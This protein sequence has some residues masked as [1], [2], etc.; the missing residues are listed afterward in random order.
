V[1]EVKPEAAN[2]IPVNSEAALI[3]DILKSQYF[4]DVRSVSQA[5]VRIRLGRALGLD[6]A[7]AMMG[8]FINMQGK[9]SMSANL[10][11][12][13]IKTKLNAKGLR[14][15][16]YKILEHTAQKCAIQVWERIDDDW[17]EC[18]PPEVS[19]IEQFKFLAVGPNKSN[20]INY[21]KNMLFARCISNIAK[22]H[23]A[24]VF[25]GSPVYLPDEIPNSGLEVDGETLEVKSSPTVPVETEATPW[26][27]AHYELQQLMIECQTDGAWLKTALGA[28]S[29]GELS[30]EAARRGVEFLRKRQELRSKVP[31]A[32]AP[33]GTV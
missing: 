8:L 20:W 10:M 31:A 15:Y 1:S 23:C 6:E 27:P 17:E 32:T 24:D 7:S 25:G 33:A 16:K 9:L 19:T 14:Q 22:F 5:A 30:E 28:S 13:C 12:R 26:T 29:V 21:P 2:V 3:Q 11:A 4:K 18:G